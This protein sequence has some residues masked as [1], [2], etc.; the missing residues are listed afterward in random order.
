MTER[1]KLIKQL[2]ENID[3]YD[4]TWGSIADFIFADRKRI[5]EPLV[6]IIELK[7]VQFVYVLEKDLAIDQTL[8]N[9]QL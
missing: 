2:Q 8:K 5:V 1:E 7:K 9:A 4:R 6:N 3:S